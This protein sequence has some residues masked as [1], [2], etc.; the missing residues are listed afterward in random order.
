MPAC[1]LLLE[2]SFN[3][4]KATPSGV[5]PPYFTATTAGLYNTVLVVQRSRFSNFLLNPPSDICIG[6]LS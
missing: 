4:S 6:K 1:V 3:A 2:W 5:H